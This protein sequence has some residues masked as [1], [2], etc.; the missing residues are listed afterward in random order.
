MY[1]Y[2]QPIIVLHFLVHC[3]H[4][5]SETLLEQNLWRCW[6]L[7]LNME[8]GMC[9]FLIGGYSLF[10]SAFI[11]YVYFISV[12][13]E[14]LAQFPVQ[15]QLQWWVCFYTVGYTPPSPLFS[16]LALFLEGFPVLQLESPSPPPTSSHPCLLTLLFLSLPLSLLLS[17]FL[18]I[19]LFLLPFLVT[20]SFLL[21]SLLWPPTSS[22][23]LVSIFLLFLLL[24]LN[25]QILYNLHVYLSFPEILS[26]TYFRFLL[27]PTKL[28]TGSC[29]SRIN[30]R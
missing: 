23:V 1:A 14:H 16:P 4:T 30:V 12:W 8:K 27:H 13:T 21:P 20:L 2:F 9:N 28:T 3:G 29:F 6:L 5:A 22:S 15:R 18:L 11:L 26:H 19:H 7:L 25:V 10:H 17:S 24:K